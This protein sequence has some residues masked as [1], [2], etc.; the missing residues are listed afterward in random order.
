[1]SIAGFGYRARR[2]SRSRRRMRSPFPDASL[3]G[4]ALLSAAAL[5]ALSA[6][7]AHAIING[8]NVPDS[9]MPQ[10]GHTADAGATGRGTGTVIY[11]NLFRA[12]GSVS[13]VLTA[14]H[15]NAT[16]FRPGGATGA[17]LASNVQHTNRNFL[18]GQ[19]G[20][21][22]DSDMTL[23]QFNNPIANVPYSTLFRGVNNRGLL[24]VAG[25]NY[26]LV[27]YDGTFAGAQKRRGSFT[28]DA[29]SANNLKAQATQ[30]PPAGAAVSEGGDS[31]GP[32]Y[33][34]TAASNAISAIHESGDSIDDSFQTVLRNV[35][36]GF[37]YLDWIDSYTERSVYW[38][39]LRIG[40]GLVDGFEAD[41]GEDGLAD[42]WTDVQ[43]NHPQLGLVGLSANWTDNEVIGATNGS[44][45]A[46]FTQ[47]ARAQGNWVDP[48]QPGVANVFSKTFNVSSAA[49]V[50]VD[51]RWNS[52]L[53]YMDVGVQQGNGAINWLGLTGSTVGD[54]DMWI[55]RTI[56]V[57]PGQVTV[58][59][60]SAAAAPEP[61][62]LALL[63]LVG[64][65]VFGRV[66][67]R[68]RTA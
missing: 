24:P 32:Y 7:P 64:G 45:G 28:I 60:L 43:V 61:A 36:P 17:L 40:G 58:Y 42:G 30:P 9:F 53:L 14:A 49:N 23:L 34:G 52:L 26:E 41:T 2:L 4:A 16:T 50:E 25:N 31:G 27:A 66:A 38:D 18:A 35:T 20:L 57:Q 33:Q 62:S 8:A 59:L 47:G 22:E 63:T 10:V 39:N 65:T 54:L 19:T 6:R 51:Q 37:R 44:S 29:A 56:A 55:N 46:L 15:V 67:M 48:G 68:R 5:A 12:G 21:T 3:I 13:F 1:M 11:N